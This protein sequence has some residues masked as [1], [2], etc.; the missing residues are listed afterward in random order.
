[1]TKDELIKSLK[2]PKNGA[3]TMR[4]SARGGLSKSPSVKLSTSHGSEQPVT[5]RYW[6]SWIRD[7][8]G[9]G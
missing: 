9:I 5:K 8:L 1:M 6:L 7:G 3:H 2:D 4:V